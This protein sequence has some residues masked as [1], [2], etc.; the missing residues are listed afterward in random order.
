MHMTLQSRMVFALISLASIAGAASAQRVSVELSYREEPF[1]ITGR[2]LI[3]NVISSDVCMTMPSGETWCVAESVNVA[4]YLNGIGQTSNVNIGGVQQPLGFVVDGTPLMIFD[5][6]GRFDRVG[7]LG[8]GAFTL[9]VDFATGAPR[10]VIRLFGAEVF[11]GGSV[12]FTRSF[13]VFEQAQEVSLPPPGVPCPVDYNGDGSNDFFD[14]IDWDAD[15]DAPD[16]MADVTADS[17][18]TL[19]D[20]NV[21]LGAIARECGAIRL[22]IPGQ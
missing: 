13:L 4:E 1:E 11:Y 10:A 3:I 18:L 22:P 5:S 14:L 20:A 15:F 6:D 21:M 7:S 12:L 9:L 2:A 8:G 19:Y 16:L 17:V